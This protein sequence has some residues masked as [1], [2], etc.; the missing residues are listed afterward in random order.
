MNNIER[1]VEL[2]HAGRRFTFRVNR[3]RPLG[4]WH[5]ETET[6][7]YLSSL[8]FTGDEDTAFFRA[9]ADTVIEEGL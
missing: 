7:T 1:V 5:V 8:P 6:G 9:L 3:R 4:F 2:D